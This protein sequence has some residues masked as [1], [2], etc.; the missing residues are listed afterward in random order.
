MTLYR[1]HFLRTYTI[2][3]LSNVL[4]LSVEFLKFIL[5]VYQQYRHFSHHNSVKL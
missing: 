5:K 4:V 2:L 3:G 1:I